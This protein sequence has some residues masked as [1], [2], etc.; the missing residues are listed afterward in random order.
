MNHKSKKKRTGITNDRDNC[1][2]TFKSLPLPTLN[3]TENNSTRELFSF[4]MFTFKLFK[5]LY[6]DK[7]VVD[8][9]Q[10]QMLKDLEFPYH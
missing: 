8:M 2:F 10:I 9:K 1:R 7:I 3:V 4:V 6:V 5:C